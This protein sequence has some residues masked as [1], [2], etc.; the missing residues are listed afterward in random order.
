MAESVWRKAEV[1][2]RRWAWLDDPEP[3]FI[4]TG[5]YGRSSSCEQPTAIEARGP[6]GFRGG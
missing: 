4:N 1:V 5:I 3:D 6:S 2:L